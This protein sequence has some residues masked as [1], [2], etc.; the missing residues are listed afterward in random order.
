MKRKRR[1]HKRQDS[2]DSSSSD[3][4]ASDGSDY[5]RKRSKEKIHQK[6]DP[7]KLFAGLTEKLLTTAYKSNIIRFKLDEDPLQRRIYFLTFVESLEMIFSQY[8]ETCEVHIDYPKI[9]G[10]N[11]KYFSRNPIRNILHT[12]IDVHIRRLISEFL[13]DGI[14]CIEKL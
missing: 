5:I 2:S 3:S 8:K 11:I 14:K 1:K 7:I 4:D 9:G 12:N 13:G 10:E 6:K